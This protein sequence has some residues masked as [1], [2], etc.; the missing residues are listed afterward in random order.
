VLKHA[1][2]PASAFLSGRL[3]SHDDE[4]SGYHFSQSLSSQE[5]RNK[6]RFSNKENLLWG[7]GCTAVG[8]PEEQIEHRDSGEKVV[9]YSD[10]SLSCKNIGTS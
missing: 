1:N 6:G 3:I 4:K 7:V 8:G 2:F 10:L 5:N 9:G